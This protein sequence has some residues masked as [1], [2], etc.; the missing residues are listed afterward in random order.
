MALRKQLTTPYQ[1]TF[2]VTAVKVDAIA[3]DAENQLVHLGHSLLASD[4]SIIQSDRPETLADQAYA[5]FNAR[6]N[7][8]GA[9]GMS[10][11]DASLYVALEYLPGSGTISGDIKTLDTPHT[12]DGLCNVLKVESYAYNVIDRLVHIGYSKL[13]HPSTN[14]MTFIPYTLSGV[15]Y[16]EFMARLDENELTMSV[17][18]AEVT[19]C[20]ENLPDAGTIVD[21]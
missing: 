1:I 5:N 3:V 21:V 13:N 15:E 8:L 2:T 6:K 12:I 4:G 7:E 20:L 18:K 14:L 10:G 19:T 17:T 16:D 11:T 9:D